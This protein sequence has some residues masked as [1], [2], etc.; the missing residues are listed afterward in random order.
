MLLL[1]PHGLQFDRFLNICFLGK[2][3][4]KTTAVQYGIF[5]ISP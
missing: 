5:S 2:M 3:D 1:Q 4:A